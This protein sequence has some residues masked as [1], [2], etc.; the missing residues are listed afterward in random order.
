MA[1]LF[2]SLA[3]FSVRLLNKYKRQQP[4]VW[5]D[6]IGR[7]RR[8]S[9]WK[10]SVGVAVISS[11]LLCM[12]AAA[13]T[14]HSVAV[15]WDPSISP[16]VMGYRVYRGTSSGGPYTRISE[17][18]V[19]NTNYV[20]YRVEAGTAYYYI[21]TA[22][23]AANNE[24][25]PSNQAPAFVGAP[26]GSGSSGSTTSGSTASAS[27]PFGGFDTPADNSSGLSGTISV[28]GWALDA[29]QVAK[30]DIWREPVGGEPVSP[31]GLVYI[32]D[33]V[34]ATG[35][36]ADIQAAYPN[37]PFNNRAGWGYSM[38]TTNFPNNGGNP[39]LGNGTYKLHAIAHNT[40][41]L[42]T[43]LGAHTITVANATQ[44]GIPSPG[45]TPIQF[46][47]TPIQSPGAPIQ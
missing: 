22:V 47:G 3:V 30:V 38:D 24:S 1:V 10:T 29:V 18:L 13:Q 39:S 46:G 36:R 40:S 19:A 34:F 9:T 6:S 42:S 17:G 25:G 23:D 12:S 43:D 16:G 32:G 7:S 4:H 31:N 35:T 44:S 14:P 11:V 20:D 37:Y 2:S 41:E 15:T 27:V 8:I 28:T 5:M 21:V 45:G 26:S 33:A